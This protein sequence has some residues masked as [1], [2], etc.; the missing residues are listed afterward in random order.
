MS[1]TNR[2][3]HVKHVKHERTA[4]NMFQ[5]ADRGWWMEAMITW[6]ASVDMKR[7]NLQRQGIM[8]T[9][10]QLCAHGVPISSNT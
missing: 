3:K 10:L 9:C 1:R 6:P 8:H 4:S 2:I 5:M 7:I